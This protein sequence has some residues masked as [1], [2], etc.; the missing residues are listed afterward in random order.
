[1][2][3][4][5]YKAVQYAW[6]VMSSSCCSAL[7]R[8]KLW[9]N[10]VD[11][12]RNVKSMKA[13]TGLVVNRKAGKVVIGDNVVFNNYG[14]QSWYC[15]CKLMVRE[16]AS[17]SI[18]NDVGMNGVLIYCN[19]SISIGNYVKIGGGTRIFDTDHHSL[20]YM[21]RREYAKDAMGCVSR[22]ITIE[23]DVFIGA[24]CIVG[25]GV[26]I[27]AR[28]IVAAGSVVVKNIPSGEIWGG[29]PARFIRKI[30]E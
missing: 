30:T 15:K 29:N 22:P 16:G 6:V 18:G 1:M 5:V 23:D 2:I 20:D 14:D 27:G 26:T 24:G 10:G 9:L 13:V 28:S 11:F 3:R 25:K 12:G 8:I 21:A 7:F 4:F 19:E 17:L